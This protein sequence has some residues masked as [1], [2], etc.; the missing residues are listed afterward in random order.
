MKYNINDKNIIQVFSNIKKSIKDKEK[1]ISELYKIDAKYS[2]TKI[3][4]KK[5]QNII[6]NFENEK[7]DLSKEQKILIHYNGNPYITINLIILS[8]LTKTTIILDIDDYFIGIN[9]L[10]VKIINDILKSFQTDELIYLY[11][12]KKQYEN[13]DK[14][15]CIDNINKYNL[16]L[17]NKNNIAKFYDYNYMNFYSNSNDF[18]ELEELIFIYAEKNQ[19]PIESFSELDE[20]TAINMI[21]KAPGKTVILFTNNENTKK[22]F[23]KNILNKRIFIN[24]NPFKE[25]TEIISKEIF[26]I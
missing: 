8:I 15:I 20:E 4:T 25:Q 1:E 19:I 5:I 16:Y 11:D 22:D 10:M 26:Y 7:I 21:D 3:S 14:I 18:E 17:K 23:Q 24:D 13:I 9:T 2:A 12:A 6:D